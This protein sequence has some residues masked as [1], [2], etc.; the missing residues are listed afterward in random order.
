[1]LSAASSQAVRRPA[2]FRP[3]ILFRSGVDAQSAP[4]FLTIDCS[5]NR[6]P[7][8]LQRKIAGP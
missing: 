3:G 2:F 7:Y 6:R 8:R 4:L 5:Q 1:M